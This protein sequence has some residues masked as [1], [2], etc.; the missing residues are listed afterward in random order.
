MDKYKITGDILREFYNAPKTLKEVFGDIEKDVQAE[1]QVVCRFIVNNYEFDEK[2]EKKFELMDLT[3]VETLEFWTDEIA[4]L[5]P[6][7]IQAWK[8]ALPELMSHCDEIAS[9]IRFNGFKGHYLAINRLIENCEFLVLSLISLKQTLGEEVIAQFM[10]WQETQDQMQ[11]L[12]T[13]AYG[14][15]EK[16]DF[17]L[18]ADVLEFDLGHNLGQWLNFLNFAEK[19]AQKAHTSSNQALESDEFADRLSSSQREFPCLLKKSQKLN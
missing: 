1:K 11:H 18:L 6:N 14:A 10:D 15:I 19:Y 3:E 5:L 16:K 13:E 7:I 2:A 9:E 8:L 17:V 4:N 12:V